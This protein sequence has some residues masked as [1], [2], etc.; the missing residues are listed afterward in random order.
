M[1][2]F[3]KFL[4]LE[5]ILEMCTILICL[6]HGLEL[7][8]IFFRKNI[9]SREFTEEHDAKQTNGVKLMQLNDVTS[10]D[11][12]TGIALIRFDIELPP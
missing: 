9:I 4:F 11:T 8:A 6:S 7:N 2:N 12:L 3:P 5:E 1:P 10:E